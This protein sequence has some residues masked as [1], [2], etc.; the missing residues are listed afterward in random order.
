NHASKKKIPNQP[1]THFNPRGRRSTF[2][3]DGIEA[4]I[5]DEGERVRME[6]TRAGGLARGPTAAPM[7]REC[8][9]TGF[10][11]CGPTQ[12]HGTKGAVGLV[13]WFEKT[14]NTFEISECT[15]GKKVKF[16][17]ATLHGR[18]L[19]WWNSQVAT[20]GRKVAN[21]RPWTEVKQMTIDEFCPTEEV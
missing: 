9:F 12:F 10:I 8:L 21:G 3:R 20:L 13:C 2:V 1:S 18:A 19:T 16:A 17:T 4:A 7:D 15:E 14:E 6:E 11:K 5:R